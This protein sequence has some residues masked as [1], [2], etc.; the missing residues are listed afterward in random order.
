LDITSSS[1]PE[2][3]KHLLRQRE[4]FYSAESLRVFAR[5]TVPP[6]TFDKLQCEILDGVIDIS[7]NTH[8]DGLARMNEVIS[9]STHIALTSN[10]LVTVIHTKDRQGICHQLANEGKLTWVPSAREV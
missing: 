6:G 9:Q 4:R 1:K 7:E 10:P 3:I 8:R 5:D 2:L